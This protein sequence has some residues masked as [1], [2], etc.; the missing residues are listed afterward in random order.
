MKT[1]TFSINLRLNQIRYPKLLKH[2]RSAREL[3]QMPNLV[4]KRMMVNNGLVAQIF[5]SGWINVVL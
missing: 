1:L 2:T 5:Y 3:A 4:V